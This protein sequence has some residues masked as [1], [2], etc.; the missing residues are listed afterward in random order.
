[1]TPRRYHRR[2]AGTGSSRE[3]AINKR[4]S[5]QPYHYANDTRA[6]IYH[7]RRGRPHIWG[8]SASQPLRP[9]DEGIARRQ[10]SRRNC[11]CLFLYL[12]RHFSHRL[13]VRETHKVSVEHAAGIIMRRLMTA[14][15]VGPVT[16]IK[17]SQYIKSLLAPTVLIN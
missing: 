12:H 17:I 2:A 13:N 10:I 1:M 5:H 3:I 16:R 6:R 11:G 9:S 14:S 7:S 8:P 4:R 15:I